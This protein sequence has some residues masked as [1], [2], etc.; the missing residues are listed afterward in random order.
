MK[1]IEVVVIILIILRVLTLFSG[2]VTGAIVARLYG[3]DFAAGLS[4]TH[5]GISSIQSILSLLGTVVEGV[6]E[7]LEGMK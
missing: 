4:W 2:P 6:V 7:E 5:M 3:L 1:K